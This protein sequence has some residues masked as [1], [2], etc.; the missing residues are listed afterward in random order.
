MLDSY[1]FENLLSLFIPPDDVKYL[2]LFT[3][4]NPYGKK[5]KDIIG[6]VQF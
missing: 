4:S 3:K 6:Y 2:A 1:L 5:K